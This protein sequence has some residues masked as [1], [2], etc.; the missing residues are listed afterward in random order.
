M[1][2][3][4]ENLEGVVEHEPKLGELDFCFEKFFLHDFVLF[5][6]KC[7]PDLLLLIII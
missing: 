4:A 3:P 1:R 5:V 7:M 6:N 2:L